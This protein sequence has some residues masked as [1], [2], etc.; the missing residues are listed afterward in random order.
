MTL[1]F[2][3][4]LSILLKGKKN[5]KS[6]TA[7]PESISIYFNSLVPDTKLAEFANSVDFN[8][9]AHNEPPHLDPHCLPSSF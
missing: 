4:L 9:V 8:E 5:Q 7:S 1:K 6:R 2:I 3:F